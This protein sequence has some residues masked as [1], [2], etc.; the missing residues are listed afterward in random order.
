M[1]RDDQGSRT[2]ADAGA[3]D[4]GQAY[5]TDEREHDEPGAPIPEHACTSPNPEKCV[6]CVLEIVIAEQRAAKGLRP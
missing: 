3:F 5:E 6:L 2:E 4:R 1:T